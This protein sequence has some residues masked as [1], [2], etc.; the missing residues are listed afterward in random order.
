MD[1]ELTTEE[2]TLSCTVLQEKLSKLAQQKHNDARLSSQIRNKLEGEVISKYWTG[3][4]KPHA[5][6][7]IIHRF[8]KD[9]RAEVPQYETNSQRMANM[10]RDYHNEIQK[11]R[12][13]VQPEIREEKIEKVLGRTTRKVTEEQG[14]LM[15]ARLTIEEVRYALRRS[16]NYKA[17]G[18]DGIPY[19]VWKVLDQRY[20]SRKKENKKGFDVLG[21]MHRVYNDIENTEWSRA[22][23]SQGAGCARSTKKMIRRI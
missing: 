21:M 1:E 12:T 4:N 19:E 9:K 8:V 17:P 18:L 23:A 6:R 13:E 11:E 7:E 10:A 5:P 22:P 15:K 3:I 2:I 20:E 14:D 16:A